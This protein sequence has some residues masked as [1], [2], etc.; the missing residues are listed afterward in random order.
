MDS[1]FDVEKIHYNTPSSTSARPGRPSPPPATGLAPLRHA[2]TPG[3]NP[4]RQLGGR[5]L[6]GRDLQAPLAGPPFPSVTSV[7]PVALPLC[8]QE[9]F[10]RELRRNANAIRGAHPGRGRESRRVIVREIGKRLAP[11]RHSRPNR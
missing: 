11:T 9:Q 1:Y 10:P 5:R 8:R 4:R 7:E 2:T 6:P 3:P